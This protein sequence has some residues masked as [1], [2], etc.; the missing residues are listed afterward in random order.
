ML[1]SVATGCAVAAEPLWSGDAIEA[2]LTTGQQAGDARRGRS[3]VESRQ[4]GLCLLCHSMT[5]ADTPLQG[6]LA[7]PLAGSGARLTA[8]RLRA[9]LV[10]SR[11]L[12]PQSIM[13]AYFVALPADRGADGGTPSADDNDGDQRFRRVGTSWR[14][15]S[16]LDAQQIEDVIAYLLTL[17]EPP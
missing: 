15:R 4:I 16:L 2:P 10:D 7:P 3:I 5:G 13:P 17:K 11:R 14:G 8:A 12:D 1:M 6:N 9:R